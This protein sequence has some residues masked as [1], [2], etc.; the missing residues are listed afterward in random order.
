MEEGWTYGA[1]DSRAVPESHVAGGRRIYRSVLFWGP[2]PI[3]SGV[4]DSVAG[5]RERKQRDYRSDVVLSGDAAVFPGG[6]ISDANAR[7]SA[8][9]LSGG[10]AGDAGKD[11]LRELED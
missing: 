3:E 5:R 9:A 1:H 2:R 6:S 8:V 10:C 4:P 7:H 11:G